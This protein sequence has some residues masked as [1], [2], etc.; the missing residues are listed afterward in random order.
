MNITRSKIILL[1]LCFTLF[2]ATVSF[3]QSSSDGSTSTRKR[4]FMFELGGGTTTVSYG[5]LVDSYFAAA[6]A[7]GAD[8]IQL[9]L[10]LDAGWAVNRKLYLVVGVDGVGDRFYDAVSY[11]QV[12]SYLYHGGLRYYPFDTGL[13]LGIEGGASR[14]VI[15][16]DVGVGGSSPWGWGGAATVAYDF[17]RRPTG[18][19]LELG[20]QVDYLA[21]PTAPVAAAALYLDLLWK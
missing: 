20:L 4:G 3:A 17:N 1:A 5:T 21:V 6:Q 12:N 7:A 9:F 2:A 8:R 10:N 16:S 11:I 13:V 18:F 19:G 15:L 14:L